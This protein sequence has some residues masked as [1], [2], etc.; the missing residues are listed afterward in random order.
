MVQQ[1]SVKGQ[2]LQFELSPYRFAYIKHE[3]LHRFMLKAK[4][5]KRELGMYL[6]MV[7]PQISYTYILQ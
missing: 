6:A 7:P 4:Q 3:S 1:E 5:K 2:Q